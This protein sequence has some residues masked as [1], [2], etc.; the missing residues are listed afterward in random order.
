MGRLRLFAQLL[1]DQ[2]ARSSKVGPAGS[3]LAALG[4]APGAA[5]GWGRRDVTRGTEP[6][7]PKRM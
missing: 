7:S 1:L 6:G 3:P 2:P 5:A 4:S